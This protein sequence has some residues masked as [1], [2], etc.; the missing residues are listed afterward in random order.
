ME[1]R[2]NYKKLGDYIREIDVRNKGLRV[3]R[4]LGVSNEK[5]FIPSIANIVGTD[6]SNYKIVKKNQ[7]AFGTVTSRNGDKLSIAILKED[8]CIVSSSYVVFEVIDESKLNPDYLMMWLRREEFDRY[9][10]FMSHGSVRELFGWDKLCDVELP[11]PDI[12]EQLKYVNDYESIQN[13]I[14]IKEAIN[15]NLLESLDT[16]LNILMSENDLEN[17]KFGDFAMFLNGY[18]FKSDS[19]LNNGKYKILTIGNVQDGKIDYS[20][21]NY[22]NEL[23]KNIPNHCILDVGD[24]LMSLTGYVGRIA[25]VDQSDCLLNQRVCKIK[26]LKQ[27]YLSGIIAL[28]RCTKVQQSMNKMSDGGTA[29]QNL[30]AIELSNTSFDFV[31]IKAFESFCNDNNKLI[32]FYMNNLAIINNLVKIQRNII[33]SIAQQ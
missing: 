27:E 15:N 26:P 12:G 8:E 9:A 10:R 19:Y 20:N 21:C 32:S 5:Y 23:P 30:S 28:M 29:Q 24:I 6:L 31:N 1:L 13:A 22:L 25:I 17:H 2:N 11:I 7:F 4:L 14:K 33:S 18:A 16:K 3:T